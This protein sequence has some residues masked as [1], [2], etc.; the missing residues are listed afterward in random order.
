MLI[1]V[2]TSMGLL[3]IMFILL[4]LLL[5]NQKLQLQIILNKI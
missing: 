3:L 4:E 1:K 2:L 5:H